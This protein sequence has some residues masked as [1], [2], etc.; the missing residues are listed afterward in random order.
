MDE[1]GVAF[2]HS[3]W[4]PT[5]HTAQHLTCHT[6]WCTIFYIN[7][8]ILK[9]TSTICRATFNCP[10]QI[11]SLYTMLPFF[12]DLKIIKFK[13]FSVMKLHCTYQEVFTHII[14]QL[15]G[16]TISMK[17]MNIHEAVKLSH[18]VGTPKMLCTWH[19]WLPFFQKFQ[20][21]QELQ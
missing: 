21:R 11:I 18:C 10:K 1:D 5:S 15:V 14:W 2:V 16:A 6:Q 3:L 9:V 4:K 8:Q 20:S 13:L 7:A 19:Q 17:S 12:Q